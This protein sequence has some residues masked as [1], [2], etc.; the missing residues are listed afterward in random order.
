MT[1]QKGKKKVKEKRKRRREMRRKIV[2]GGR[3][4]SS[5]ALQEVLADL[6][7]HINTSFCNQ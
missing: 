3:V 5:K 4:D 6:K 1:G 2:A 7:K